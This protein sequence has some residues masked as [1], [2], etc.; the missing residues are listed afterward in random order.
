[1][2]AIYYANRLT[3]R[4]FLVLTTLPHLSYLGR[5][6]VPAGSLHQA[7]EPQPRLNSCR[8][9]AAST[10]TIWAR[11]VASAFGVTTTRAV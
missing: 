10:A 9:M 8:R 3:G 11:T 7:H 5:A 1:M 2:S 6:Q 4:F